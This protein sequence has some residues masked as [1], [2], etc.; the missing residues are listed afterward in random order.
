MA[1]QGARNAPRGRRATA[2]LWAQPLAAVI[3]SCPDPTSHPQRCTLNRIK[4]PQLLLTL[5]DLLEPRVE[6]PLAS[7]APSPEKI[8][9]GYRHPHNAISS[10]PLS[11]LGF[12]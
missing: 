2:A 5:E 1:L 4:H 7:K 11:L 12:S 9:S 3:A 8:A 6:H 10:Q